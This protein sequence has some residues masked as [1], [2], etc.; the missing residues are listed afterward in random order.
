V[1]SSVRYVSLAVGLAAA[2]VIA[3]VALPQLAE[4]RQSAA[5][6]TA[7]SRGPLTA[8]NCVAYPHTC[9]Y[10]DATNTGV[11]ASVHLRSVP[12][13][14][15]SGPGWAY[16]P[17]GYV[18]VFG[19]GA[20]LS[21]L[22][23]PYDLD[24]SAS[25]V[26]IS[27]DSIVTTGTGDF[28]ISLRHTANVTVS[29]TSVHSPDNTGPDRLQYGIKDIYAD[30]S[31]TVLNADNIWNTSTAIAI[32]EGT[33][34][35]S[36][37][38]GFGYNPGDH[39]DGIASDAGSPLGLSIIH[40][41]VL[42]GLDQTDAIQLSQD[43][44]PQMDATVSRNLLAGGAYTIYAGDSS[45]PGTA[46]PTNIVITGNRFSAIYHPK[47]GTFGPAAYVATG[48]GDIWSGNIWDATAKP[49]N[50]GLSCGAA[51]RLVVLW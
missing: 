20:N 9:G 36:Y 26:T 19:N 48:P 3:E 31:G 2:V 51:A 45:D 7:V 50:E 4:S 5:S 27:D 41:T 38:H 6:S 25:D 1:S 32:S 8:N 30:S 17:A 43:F 14:V 34:E 15:S 35:N 44:G 46:T 47:S 10:P 13:Q 24:I 42:N 18:E 22:Y 40:N 16:N 33:V 49:I 29:H 28:G 39:C 23:I 37:I 21:G 11:P 12:G